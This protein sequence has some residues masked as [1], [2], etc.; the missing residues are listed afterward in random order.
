MKHLRLIPEL[1][2]SVASARRQCIDPPCLI[3]GL[4]GIDASGKGYVSEQLATLLNA[5]GI[6]T[7][8]I[9]GDGWLNPPS[10]RF[11]TIEPGR[12]FLEHGLRL[13]DLLNDFVAP[14]R[15]QGCIHTEVDHRE[16]TSAVATRR[17]YDWDDVAVA[18]VE[19]VF[20]FQP[21]YVHHFDLKIWI[22]CSNET[23]LRRAIA[24]GQEGLAPDACREA[25]QTIYFPAQQIHKDEHRPQELADLIFVN[26]E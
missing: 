22:D 5:A 4:S 18:I 13:D 20:L 11:S 24:R 1:T 26:D 10:V 15:A 14:L 12:H 3:V 23:A 8:V 19:A 21:K 2:E 9:N 25:F 16:E 7:Q 17:R 6:R